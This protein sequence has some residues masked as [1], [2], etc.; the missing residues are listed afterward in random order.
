M[1][2]FKKIICSF[3]GLETSETPPETV[4]ETGRQKLAGEL[5]RYNQS[6]AASISLREVLKGQIRTLESREAAFQSAL[7]LHLRSGSDEESGGE[8][9]L[10]LESV[11]RELGELRPQLEEVETTSKNIT[12]AREAALETARKQL[13]D[14]KGSVDAAQIHQAL[15]EVDRLGRIKT[16]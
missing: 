16:K 8:T 1:N 13:E 12:A 5:A 7:E 6:L 3:F 2:R 9:A 10:R 14:L 15:K 11:R 4:I